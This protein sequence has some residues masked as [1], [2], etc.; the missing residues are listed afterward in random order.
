LFRDA[1][2]KRKG[3]LMMEQHI[4]P[5]RGNDESDQ[6]KIADVIVNWQIRRM[7]RSA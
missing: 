4:T 2:V 3:K 7:F 5:I 1:A 6:K